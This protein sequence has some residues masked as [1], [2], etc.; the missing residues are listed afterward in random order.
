MHLHQTFIFVHLAA[1]NFL[2]NVN[3]TI[4]VFCSIIL[5]KLGETLPQFGLRNHCV[6]ILYV[7]SSYV[8]LKTQ[9]TV[10]DSARRLTHQTKILNNTN[11][12]AVCKLILHFQMVPSNVYNEIK[13]INRTLN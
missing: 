4:S 10:S 13:M 9:L 11:I 2:T 8:I 3:L 1:M 12:T 6:S 7:P 5:K